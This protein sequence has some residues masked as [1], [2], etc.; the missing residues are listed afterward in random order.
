MKNKKHI[1]LSLAVLTAITGSFFY[2]GTES[3]K[4]LSYNEFT[5]NGEIRARG[6]LVESVGKEIAQSITVR[7]KLEG[8]YKPKEI[9]NLKIGVAGLN[10]KGFGLYDYKKEK[11][12]NPDRWTVKEPE[13][14][15]LTEA[16]I[17]YKTNHYELTVGRQKIQLDNGK[18]IAISNW[19]Q[20]Y[21]T[22]DAIKYVNTYFPNLKF[23]AIYDDKYNGVVPD[24]TAELNVITKQFAGNATNDS[25]WLNAQ[26]KVT[27]KNFITLYN[28]VIKN[29]NNTKG[30]NIKGSIPI[31]ESMTA[32][33]YAEYAIQKNEM[34]LNVEPDYIYTKWDFGNEAF[35]IGFTYSEQEK[36][37]YTPYGS[38]HGFNGYA[39]VPFTKTDINVMEFFSEFKDLNDN[40]SYG[41]SYWK[42]NENSTD[43]D[44]GYEI[45]FI[46]KNKAPFLDLDILTEVAY[47][48]A[49]NDNFKVRDIVKIWF[50]IGYKF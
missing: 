15:R 6:E 9:E 3:V 43:N 19:K 5:V 39:D 20:T 14:T 34:K 17:S 32:N 42:F 13:N 12:D 38:G 8:I 2:I 37:F 27:D 7:T 40:T 46:M 30:F 22:H 44:L 10:V 4:A 23:T 21:K 1:V 33:Y 28:Y 50:Q 31:F 11:G 18:F 24:D 16:Y 25:Y 48:K 47:Y 45:D 49:P 41:L 36:Y 26:L 29:Y 35:K